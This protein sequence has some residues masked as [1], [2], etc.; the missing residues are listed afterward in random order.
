M[1]IVR[2]RREFG[3][4]CLGWSTRGRV[5]RM[6]GPESVPAVTIVLGTIVFRRRHGV[7]ALR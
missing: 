4:Q 2:R 3:P 1:N 7:S 6:V 5:L